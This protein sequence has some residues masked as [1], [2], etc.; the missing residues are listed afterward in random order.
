MRCDEMR[1]D[2]IFFFL[3][4]LEELGMLKLMFPNDQ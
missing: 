1:W 3:D 4:G 2:L